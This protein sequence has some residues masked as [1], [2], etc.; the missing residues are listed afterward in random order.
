[1]D[2]VLSIGVSKFWIYFYHFSF[3]FT[4]GSDFL[5]HF[6]GCKVSIKNGKNVVFSSIK[7]YLNTI[8]RSL[9]YSHNKSI[10]HYVHQLPLS[11]VSRCAHT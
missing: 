1:M 4:G 3:A 6:P 2:F 10:M 5:P 7:V 9:G 11:R 8:V